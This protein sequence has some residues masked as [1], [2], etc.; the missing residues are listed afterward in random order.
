MLTWIGAGGA[1]MWERCF[2]G[3]PTLTVVV[4]ANQERTT[5]DVAS[6]GAIEYM[7]WYD[8]LGAEDYVRI[9]AGAIENP[10]RV[11]QIGEA[12]LGILQT[13]SSSVVDEMQRLI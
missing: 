7:G 9:I 2:L 8:Q 13:E 3:L 11:K 6:V 5:E 12:A 4:A 1:A 10:H